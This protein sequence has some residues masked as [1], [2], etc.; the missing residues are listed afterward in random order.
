MS[1]ARLAQ[2]LERCYAPS[3]AYHFYQPA[4]PQGPCVVFLGG[5]RSDMGGTKALYLEEACRK[6]RQPYIRFDYRGH[7]Q[8]GGSFIEGT[9]GA[10]FQDALD[11]IDQ[12]ASGP[13]LLVGSSMGGWLSLLVLKARP[14]RV[15]GLVGIA[16]AP[17][18]TR[19]IWEERM[20]EEQRIT[21]RRTGL[22]EVPNHYSTEPYIITKALIDDGKQHF[23]LE[24]RY[25]SHVPVR[26]LQ[27]RLDQDVIWTTALALQD[28]L[29]AG[30]NKNVHVVLV[31]EGDHRLSQPSDLALI[32]NTVLE[33]SGLSGAD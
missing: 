30:G 10:W 3:L 22:L 12:V 21:M 19:E 28:T 32:D 9:I 6:R 5:F 17:D 31:E 8:S 24:N 29:K 23:I 2:H 26:L 1:E 27:G 11:I 13:V 4:D 33:L 20:S 16:A 7:G 25:V 18:F 15:C 14:E